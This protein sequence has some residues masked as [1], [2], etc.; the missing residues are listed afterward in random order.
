MKVYIVVNVARQINGE[1]I[2]VKVEKAFKES[3]KAEEY[4]NK[5][6]NPYKDLVQ[7]SSGFSVECMCS[8]G[9]F[10]IEIEE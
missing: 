9:V 6:E 5:S 1:F 2:F 8:R 4:A 3:K 7:N 10:D